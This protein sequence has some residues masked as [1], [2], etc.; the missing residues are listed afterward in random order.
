MPTLMAPNP[1]QFRVKFGTDTFDFINFNYSDLIK[2]CFEQVAFAF[3]SPG[4]PP[5]VLSLLLFRFRTTEEEGYIET[6][7]VLVLFLNYYGIVLRD[8]LSSDKKRFQF[9]YR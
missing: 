8:E 7:K 6:C 1:E 2:L 9:S 5:S 4:K 3:A